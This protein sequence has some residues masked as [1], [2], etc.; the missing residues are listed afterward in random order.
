MHNLLLAVCILIPSLL[1]APAKDDRA[2]IRQL[3]ETMHGRKTC[4]GVVIELKHSTFYETIA[5]HEIS[6]V[7]GKHR[8]ELKGM[9]T[10]R[11]SR[12][13]KILTIR[14]KPGRGDFGSGNSVTVTIKSSALTGF[15]QDP[16]QLS[17]STDV[18]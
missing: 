17:I 13:G 10:W 6:V 9:M 16:I 11:V 3:T 12:S 15:P 8:R 2:V 5:R 18:R 14:F 1:G 4:R 7:E